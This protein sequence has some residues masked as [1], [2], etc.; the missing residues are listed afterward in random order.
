MQISFGIPDA[1]FENNK[2]KID[3]VMA[4]AIHDLKKIDDRIVMQFKVK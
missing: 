2:G 4:T 3:L 1:V